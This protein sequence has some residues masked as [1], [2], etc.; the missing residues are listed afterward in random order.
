MDFK[1]AAKRVFGE[2]AM[3]YTSKGYGCEVSDGSVELWHSDFEEAKMCFIIDAEIFDENK[4]CFCAY[5]YP[6][7]RRRKAKCVAALTHVLGVGNEAFDEESTEDNELYIMLK[8]Y[9]E[10]D[11]SD[12]SLETFD[13][14]LDR[15][16]DK[17][18]SLNDRIYQDLESIDSKLEEFIS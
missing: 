6:H 4:V 18:Y 1:E 2:I 10:V 5:L 3:S 16:R 7:D 15:V 8:E 9:E 11:I 14:Y 12:L 17:V 13:G